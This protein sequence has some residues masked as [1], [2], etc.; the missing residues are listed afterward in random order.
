MVLDR[1][2]DNRNCHFKREGNAEVAR[3]HLGR[4]LMKPMSY[5][6]LSGQPVGGLV[7]Y[8][9][10]LPEETLVVLDDSALFVGA[11]R[12]RKKGSAGGHNG[13][14]SVLNHLSTEAVPRLRIGIGTSNHSMTDH[15][16]STFSEEEIPVMEQA[17]DRACE[18]IEIISS[19]GMETAMNRF[20]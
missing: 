9:K 8:Y 18:A 12:I 19:V 14:A 20:N 17:I 16:L 10:I 11:L 13:L 1:L 6:N 2:A 5:M 3:D 7:H 15:V 4:I